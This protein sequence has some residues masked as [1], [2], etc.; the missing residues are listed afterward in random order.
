MQD[1]FVD[2]LANVMILNNVARLDFI[3]VDSID[4]AT[5]QGQVS[6]SLRVAI[7]LDALMDMTQQLDQIR[8]QIAA[9]IARQQVATPIPDSPAAAADTITH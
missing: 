6:P 7:P 8:E 9:E 3:R 1:L 4:T 2:R 5:N